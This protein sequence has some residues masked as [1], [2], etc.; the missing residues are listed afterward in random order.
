MEETMR[1]LATTAA[2]AVLTALPAV[3]QFGNPAGMTAQTPE[4][5]PG[6]PASHQPNAQDRLFVYLITTGGLAEI[7]AGRSADSKGQNSAVKEYGRRM[8]QDHARANSQLATLAN[9]A[10]IPLP[11]SLDPDHRAM[12]A[13]LDRLSGGQFDLAYMQGQIIDHQ[14]TL[15]L[16]EW[17]MSNGQDPELQRFAQATL[18]VVLQHLQMAQGLMSQL[19]GA[20]P[21]GL[22]ATDPVMQR[23]GTRDRRR[24]DQP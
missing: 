4:S 15:T 9:A 18:P 5:E 21:Q 3:A 20:P 19:T 2:L 14:K 11:T 17:V 23:T 10:R 12:Q 24:A 1:R 16:L 22:A 8:A 13:Q 6:M 7:G